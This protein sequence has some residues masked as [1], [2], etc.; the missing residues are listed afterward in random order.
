M[1]GRRA[2]AGIEYATWPR[3]VFAYP[4]ARKESFGE[5]KKNIKLSYTYDDYF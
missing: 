4:S 1:Y 3:S 2:T 5:Q